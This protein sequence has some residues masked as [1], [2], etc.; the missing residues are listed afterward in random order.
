MTATTEA[1]RP[2]RHYQRL[3]F[4]YNACY[5]H[6]SRPYIVPTGVLQHLLAA[7][8]SSLLTLEDPFARLNH[9]RSPPVYG[10]EP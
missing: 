3:T 7:A 1:S 2:G 6:P 5:E 8:Q 10:V 9:A 4:W